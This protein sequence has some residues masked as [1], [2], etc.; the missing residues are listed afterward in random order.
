MFPGDGFRDGKTERRWS[1]ARDRGV[2]RYQLD[3]T[4]AA[5]CQPLESN[6]IHL[7]MLDLR[8]MGSE[9][10]RSRLMEGEFARAARIKDTV[11]RQLYLGGRYGLRQLL[12]KYSGISNA[13]LKFGYSSR[14]KP[15]L[16]HQEPGG[17]IRFNYTLSKDKVLY[18]LS[19]QH[20][21]GVDMEVLPR[22]I[23]HSLMAKRHLTAKEQKVWRELPDAM[24]HNAMLC[25]WTRKEAYGKTLGVGIRYHMNRVTLFDHL[26][27][28][29]WRLRRCGIFSGTDTQNMPD[30]FEGVQLQMPFDAEACLMYGVDDDATPEIRAAQLTIEQ[31][32]ETNAI[33]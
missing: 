16:L 8:D 21:I 26:E 7:W 32:R 18:G 12:S 19:R 3:W 25:C 22:E 5:I 30:Q 2:S 13:E 10:L 4:G 17:E 29:R 33:C 14:G 15:F 31:M 1:I 11:K 6:Q 28:A 9:V 20:E 24:R 27:S 23:S